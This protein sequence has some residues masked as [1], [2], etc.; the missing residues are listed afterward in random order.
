MTREQAETIVDAITK[1]IL[2][3]S[4]IG[5]EMEWID[6]ETRSEIRETWV[7]IVMNEVAP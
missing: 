7:G 5:D 1:D 2:D 4:G 6:D 3:R